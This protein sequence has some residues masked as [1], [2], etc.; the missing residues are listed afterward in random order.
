MQ[1]RSKV[2]LAVGI[3]LAVLAGCA[4]KAAPEAAPAVTTPAKSTLA[5]GATATPAAGSAAAAAPA[6]VPTPFADAV[7]RAGRRLYE[8]AAQQLGTQERVLV[9]DPLID[10]SS[11]QQTIASNDMGRNPIVASNRM[12][13]AEATKRS[14]VKLAFMQARCRD[15]PTLSKVNP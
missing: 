8:S 6:L 1:T 9:L 4:N 7:A 13:P 14:I 12:K 11:G 3:T 15:P 10:A 5:P 2:I